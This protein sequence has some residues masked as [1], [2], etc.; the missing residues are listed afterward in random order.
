MVKMERL[1]W[2]RMACRGRT[3]NEISECEV[4]KKT[5]QN[6]A[7]SK[8]GLDS[9]GCKVKDLDGVGAVMLKH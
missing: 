3:K 4:V 7:K 2:L 1:K 5:K 8:V 6:G 9:V